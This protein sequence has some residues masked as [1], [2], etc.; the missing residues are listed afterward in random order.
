[1]M[2]YLRDF[3][4]ILV[5]LTFSKHSA[6]GI[7]AYM[8]LSDKRILISS[9]SIRMLDRYIYCKD[10]FIRDEF[11][12]QAQIWNRCSLFFTNWTLNFVL[13]M[14]SFK[15]KDP[16]PLIC[17]TPFSI[18]ASPY[19]FLML[20]LLSCCLHLCNVESRK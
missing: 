8:L 19:H 18:I 12:G 17:L 14:C 4:Y 20:K 16:P 11:V 1:M 13:N 7:H 3:F 10:S 9:Y 2:T 15:I 6:H 5:Q